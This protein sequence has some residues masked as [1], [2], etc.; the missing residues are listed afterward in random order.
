M[1]AEPLFRL[2][3]FVAALLARPAFRMVSFLTVGTIQNNSNTSPPVAVIMAAGKSTRMKSA[4]PKALHRICGKEVT[5]HVVDSCVEAGI[6]RVIVI[7]GYEAEQVRQGLGGDIEYVTQEVQ[8]GTGHAVMMAAPLLTDPDAAVVVLPGDAPLISRQTLEGLVERHRNS[9]AAA[10]LLTAC[11]DDP[12]SYG[13]IVRL[14]PDGRVGRIVET[15]DATP[16][17]KA[18]NEIAS[19][20]YVFQA[21]PLLECLKSLKSENAQNEYYLTDVVEMLS[22]SDRLVDAVIVD[23][24]CEVMGINTRV[25]LAAAASAMRTRINRE[26][27][28]AGVTIVDPNTTY[29]DVDVK[30]GGDTIIHPC[31]IIERG[32]RIGSNCT[33]GPFVRLSG[34]TVGDN[35][36]VDQREGDA[37]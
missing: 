18:I 14:P 13:R 37:Q 25:E 3:H 19:S 36:T 6:A 35:A 15:K 30:I 5:R 2:S 23:D 34:A 33:V 7:V 27:M 1:D 20:M 32:S 24:S 28:L 12:G 11:V 8:L 22:S 4:L 9:G 29:I 21:G 16:E 10:T 17:Q 26:L 31:T